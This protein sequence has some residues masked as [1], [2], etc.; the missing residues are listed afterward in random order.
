VRYPGYYNV[1]LSALRETLWKI[2]EN[3]HLCPHKC[4]INRLK[5][6]IGICRTKVKAKISSYGPHYGEEPE[7]VGKNGSGTIFFSYCNLKC[8]YCQ[9]YEISQLGE[10]K[11]VESSEL[12]EIML[13]LQDLGCH[14]INL[15]SPTHVIPQIIDAL[16][17]ARKQGLKLPLVYNSG[18]YDDVNTLKLLAGVIDIYMPDAKYGTNEAGEKYSKV[19]N[20]WD[21]NREV[22]KEMHQQVGDLVVNQN[23][24]AEEGLIIRH[25]VL[26]NQ[27]ASSFTIL[28]FIAHNLSLNTY[29]NIMTQYRPC[30]LSYRYPELARPITKSEFEEVINY[31]QKLGLKRIFY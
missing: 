24:I 26:P 3:C 16:I 6:E 7:L 28:E 23:G 13:Y 29:L 25:L 21:I 11:E 10:G 20:Y 4:H 1:D 14:N 22:L 30:Y 2:L 5:G 31:A 8:L 19:K 9:N 18:G 15:V 17:T 12:A 27:I